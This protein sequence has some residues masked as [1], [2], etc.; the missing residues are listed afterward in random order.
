M[1]CTIPAIENRFRQTNPE[2][3][4]K[5]NQQTFDT[6]NTLLDSKLFEEKDACI[7]SYLWCLDRL[8]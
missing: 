8:V 1:S 7:S 5:L 4:D 2:L 3:A 6:W